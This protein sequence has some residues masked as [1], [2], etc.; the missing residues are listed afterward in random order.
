MITLP[1]PIFPGLPAQLQP[2]SVRVM[3]PSAAGVARAVGVAS[4]AAV[5]MAVAGTGW[6]VAGALVGEAAAWQAPVRPAASVKA[7]S[8]RG[9]RR[10][11]DVA[12][13]GRVPPG[14]WRRL[15]NGMRQGFDVSA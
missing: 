12:C 10:G 3:I 1:G 13:M 5:G 15:P 9:T 4:G 6:T 2:S 11:L 8:M 14:A 7:S